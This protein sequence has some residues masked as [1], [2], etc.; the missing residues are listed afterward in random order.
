M[1]ATRIG[2]CRFYSI[3]GSEH[4]RWR[5]TLGVRSGSYDRGKAGRATASTSEERGSTMSEPWQQQ[6]QDRPPYGQPAYGG[7]PPFGGPPS[8][9]G[10]RE[11][12]QGTVI[13]V[14]GIVSLVVC[15]VLGPVAWVMGNNAMA[16]INRSP[17]LYTN[18][19]SVQ[20]GRICGIIATAFLALTILGVIIVIA[21]A[22]SSSS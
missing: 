3:L 10:M 5:A 16:D 20:A 18:Q 22:G 4:G 13:L 6:P 15:Q 21:A 1:T 14:L 19:S 17:G 8:Y 2:V 11:H 9:G 7:P 12:P